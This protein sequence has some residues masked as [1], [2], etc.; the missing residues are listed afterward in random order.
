[1]LKIR[2]QIRTQYSEER[3]AG[4]GFF[5]GGGGAFLGGGERGLGRSPSRGPGD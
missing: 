4:L 5:S 1:M 2:A 3:G